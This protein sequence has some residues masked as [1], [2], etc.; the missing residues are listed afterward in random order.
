MG[1]PPRSERDVFYINF[2]ATALS[3]VK[4]IEIKSIC[5]KWRN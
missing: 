5:Y 3:M 2:L 1:L 4:M